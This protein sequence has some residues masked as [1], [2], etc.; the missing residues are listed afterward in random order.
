MGPLGLD[1]LLHAVEDGRG[2]A[3]GRRDQEAVGRQ[4][5]DGAVVDDHPVVPAHDAVA[6]AADAQRAHQVRVEVVEQH[7]GVGTLH[8]DLA[9]GGAVDDP[10]AGRATAAHSRS[11]AASMSSPGRG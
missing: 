11:T 8:V 3:G 4:A 10:D 6:H 7:R 9:E 1:P 2:V 5:Q